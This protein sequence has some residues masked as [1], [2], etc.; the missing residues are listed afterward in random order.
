MPGFR[1]DFTRLVDDKVSIIVLMNL[2]DVDTDSIRHGVVAV[3]LPPP[4][5]AR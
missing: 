2:D 5:R 3:Y 1:A 4:A